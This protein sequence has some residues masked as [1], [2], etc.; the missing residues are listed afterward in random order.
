MKF[1]SLLLFLSI[2]LVIAP[3]NVQAQPHNLV[4]ANL[5]LSE[6]KLDKAKE[7]ID[8]ASA[9]PKTADKAKTWLERG[10][11]YYAIYTSKDSRYNEL[12][13]HADDECILAYKKFKE[14]SP[15]DSQSMDIASKLMMLGNLSIAYG[16]E[17]YNQK[18]YEIAFEKFVIS[19]DCAELTGTV[20]S[21]AL[22]NCALASERAGNTDRAIIWYEK[23]VDIGYR[24]SDCCGY[25]I[26]LLKQEGRNTEATI[27]LKECRA[28]FPMNQELLISEI[29][30]FLSQGNFEGAAQNLEQAV[31]NDPTNSVLLYS[32]GTVYN[33]LNKNEMAETAYKKALAIN[34]DYFDANYNLGALYFNQGVDINNA[35]ADAAD[36]PAYREMKKESEA[37]FYKALVYLEKAITIIPNHKGTL[38][39]LLALYG[40]IDDAENY[41]RINDLLNE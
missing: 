14:I 21:L 13:P 5:A 19:V 11:I 7:A 26:A 25:I 2:V 12:K 41:Q 40:R 28:K 35:A 36:D 15:K 39:S 31:K 33:N 38:T 22:Y 17:L 4:T 23:C 9:H 27:R 8:A 18:K 6:G 16:V 10:N 24:G 37:Y 29:N 30:V 34:P 20:D 32:L 1:L 3:S